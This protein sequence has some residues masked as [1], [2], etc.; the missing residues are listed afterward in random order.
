MLSI[1]SSVS[2]AS[3]KSF[4]GYL[5][6]RSLN[7]KVLADDLLK[8]G[9]YFSSIPIIKELMATGRAGKDIEDAIDAVMDEVGTHQFQLFDISILDRYKNSY[10]SY[11]LA[12]K[13]FFSGKYSD[14]LRQLKLVKNKNLEVYKYLLEGTIYSI[15]G[16][17]K[18]AIES[19]NLCLKNS[20]TVSDKDKQKQINLARD[21]CLAGNS[22]TNFAS[23]DFEKA[24]FSYLDIQKNS[25]IW[26]EILFDEAWNSFYMEDFNRT[27][28][29]L[30]TY[31]APVFTHIFNPEIEILTALSYL[32][33][34]LYDDASK[35]A[36]NFYKKYER[37][38]ELLN[39]FIN[40]YKKDYKAFYLLA[41]AGLANN[42]PSNDLIKRIIKDINRDPSFIEMYKNFV[43]GK[44][45]IQ[46]IKGVSDAR[47][48]KLI[49][50]T[51]KESLLTQRDIIGAYVRKKMIA[52]EKNLQKA[53]EG[54][55]YIKL[56]ILN[57]QKSA[58]YA[59]Q[60]QSGDR[61]RGD[62]QYVQRSDKQYFWTFNG[63]FWA[64]ELGDYVF[65]L[66]S[67]C[68]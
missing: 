48:R 5:I 14:S 27:L 29:K 43:K 53:F 47:L 50:A 56:E 32:F 9:F 1:A 12:K 59:R 54:M 22:R 18:Q 3:M 41:K 31:K 21:A 24:N 35:E 63:E 65:A 58:I 6:N 33:L 42:Y 61:N 38:S 34:C 40:K 60:D 2:H 51:F 39:R 17:H 16:N 66:K 23:R 64:D 7:Y 67:E 26:P 30:V 25:Q 68:K 4:E 37:D 52:Q 28:G 57:K 10:T 62:F 49:L 45:E 8:G 20:S 13:Y 55:S 11:I 46:K 36:D 19:F 15:Q 44:D